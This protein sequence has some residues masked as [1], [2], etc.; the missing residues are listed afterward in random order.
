M[1]RPVALSP[2]DPQ[3]TVRAGALI[4]AIDHLPER[5]RL[6]MG[7]HYEQ[8]MNLKE[9]A[10]SGCSSQM[11][12]SVTGNIHWPPIAG[13]EGPNYLLNP[14]IRAQKPP[15]ASQGHRVFLIAHKGLKTS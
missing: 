7:M 9:I 13:L 12:R 11:H 5:E 10:D 6:L 14:G 1:P 8:D 3:W 4:E 2:H 15:E